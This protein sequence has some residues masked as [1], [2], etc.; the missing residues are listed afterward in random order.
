MRGVHQNSPSSSRIVSRVSDLHSAPP[1]LLAPALRAASSKTHSSTPLRVRRDP[2]PQG[3]PGM[4]TAQSRALRFKVT[5]MRL[6]KIDDGAHRRIQS[7]PVASLLEPPLDDRPQGGNLYA[8]AQPQGHGSS[9]ASQL[10][11]SPLHGLAAQTCS[12][13]QSAWPAKYAQQQ[14]QQPQTSSLAE[15]VH[16]APG[17]GA[18]LHGRACVHANGK[19]AQPGIAIENPPFARAPESCHGTA[20]GEGSPAHK[21]VTL[22][23]S[24]QQGATPHSASRNDTNKPPSP[25]LMPSDSIQQGSQ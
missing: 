2:P 7:H 4:R 14:Q 5:A 10:P 9:P 11:H 13:P 21:Q 25:P 24:P 18:L 12:P 19:P 1:V 23:A 16:E 17:A 8:P 6:G 15:K 22:Q 20:A 3:A